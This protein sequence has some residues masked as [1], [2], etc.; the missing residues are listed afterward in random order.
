M[1]G[2]KSVLELLTPNHHWLK[3]VVEDTWLNANSHQVDIRDKRVLICSDVEM[4]K[5][6]S[7]QTPSP[8]LAVVETP[9][10]DE[11]PELKNLALVLDGIQDPGNL[12][13]IIRTADW[14]G[15]DYVF[16][17]D[18]TVDAYNPKTVQAAM[19]S[20]LRV[21]VIER[22]LTEVFSNYGNAH[23]Y[24]ADMNGDDLRQYRLKEPALLLIGNEGSGIKEYWKP[25]INTVITIPKFGKAE[26]LNASVA[27]S[28]ICAWWKLNQ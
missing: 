17:S 10:Y 20:L 1:E 25:Y 11:L 6:S 21:K 8:L 12:G 3:L 19:G 18:D 27:A 14:F 24:A 15:I 5:I 26:S 7:L 28:I 16:T 13:T 23:V 4:K 22:S 2:E 9:V